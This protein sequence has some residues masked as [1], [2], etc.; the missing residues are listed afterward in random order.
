[1]RRFIPLALL[2][3][4]AV[5]GCIYGSAAL[6]F[7]PPPAQVTPSETIAVDFSDL[8]DNAA[9]TL[10]ISSKF[11]VVPGEAFSFEAKSFVLPISLQSGSVSAHTENTAWTGLAARIEN[12]SINVAGDADTDG[13]FL[14]EEELDIPE[15]TYDYLRLEGEAADTAEEVAAEFH[16][17]GTKQGAEDGRVSFVIGGI[18]TGEV[19]VIILVNGI[20]QM[21]SNVAIGNGTAPQGTPSMSSASVNVSRSRTWQ[22]PGTPMSSGEQGGERHRSIISP[23]GRASLIGVPDEN[24]E[25]VEAEIGNVPE[26]WIALGAGYAVVPP[27]TT[28]PSAATLTIEMPDT[29]LENLSRYNPFLAR[30]ENDEW[31]M[32]QSRIEGDAVSGSISIGGVYCLMS[33]KPETKAAPVDIQA[34]IRT[35]AAPAPTA[36]LPPGYPWYAAALALTAAIILMGYLRRRR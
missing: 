13:V 7:T 20:E 16:L 14:A 35:P 15:G 32:V 12:I 18:E 36:S 5:C 28:F 8:P 21:R 10:T 2:L 31:Q 29:V 17:T 1:M 22:T 3:L 9:F 34:R 27:E 26:E 30:Y 23:D 4:V 25:I 6:S 11:A 33:L 19:T 24:I